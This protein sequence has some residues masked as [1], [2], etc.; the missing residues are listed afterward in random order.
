[1]DVIMYPE[2][3]GEMAKRNITQ[4]QVAAKLNISVRSFYNRL[5]GRAEFTWPEVL[6]IHDVYF[7]DLDLKDLFRKRD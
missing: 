6:Q 1:M 2:L 3:V 5:T 7:P 4:R